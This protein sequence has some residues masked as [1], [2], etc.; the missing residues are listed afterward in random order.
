MTAAP[1]EP[2][3]TAIFSVRDMPLDE[4]LSLKAEVVGSV[5]TLKVEVD[6]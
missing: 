6:G 4:E 1:T 2:L 3:I 5:A